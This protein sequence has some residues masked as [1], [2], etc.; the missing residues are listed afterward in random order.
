VDGPESA[1]P[2]TW[3]LLGWMREE[4]VGYPVHYRDRY[5]LFQV[6]RRDE[7]GSFKKIEDVSEE[8]S[9][10]L[11]DVQRSQRIASLIQDLTIEYR[12]TGRLEWHLELDSSIDRDVFNKE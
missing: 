8:I 11:L 6:T 12:R 7:A 1:T 2:E 3:R 5:W 9:S 4:Q 10:R